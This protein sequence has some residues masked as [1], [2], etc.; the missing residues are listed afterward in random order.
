MLKV[1]I[2]QRIHKYEPYDELWECLDTR[3]Y[4]YFS[5][6]GHLCVGLS[7]MQAGYE[8]IHYYA[9]YLDVL[10]LSGGNDIGEYPLRDEFEIALLKS[11]L[12]AGKKIL[13][14]CRGAQ[15]IAQCSGGE[16]VK[17]SH[18]IKQIHSLSGML[19]H[20]VHSYHRFC[21]RE[22]PQ[23]FIEIARVGDEIEAFAKDQILGIMW[24]IEREKAEESRKADR[25]LIESFLQKDWL[26]YLTRKG[27]R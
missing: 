25:E 3:L 13:G 9:H 15:V 4:Q 14:I 20:A 1:G 19:S 11:M 10:V 27:E 7:C 5:E 18:K 8:N 26:T 17:S 24:H 16:I 6:M 2:T 12:K 23:G 21:I 22:L